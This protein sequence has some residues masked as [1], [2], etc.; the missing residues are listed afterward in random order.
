[1]SASRTQLALAVDMIPDIREHVTSAW[2]LRESDLDL[3]KE[4]MNAL[5][6]LQCVAEYVDA[7]MTLLP[8]DDGSAPPLSPTEIS[9]LTSALSSKARR[10]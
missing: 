10:S 4:L 8:T 1:M 2:S 7:A 5:T 9:Q 6:M 3:A